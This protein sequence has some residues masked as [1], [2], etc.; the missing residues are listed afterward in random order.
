MSRP[1]ATSRPRGHDTARASKISFLAVAALFT[2]IVH[3]QNVT[4]A[5]GQVGYYNCPPE[6]GGGCCPTG[7]LCGATDCVDVSSVAATIT[8]T[9]LATVTSLNGSPSSSSE[10]RGHKGYLACQQP[11]HDGGDCCPFGYHCDSLVQCRLTL[12]LNEET[13]TIT[14]TNSDG[15]FEVKTTTF[16]VGPS[17]TAADR[18]LQAAITTSTK[19]TSDPP[20]TGPAAQTDSGSGG[21]TGGQVGGIVGGVVG[22]VLLLAAAAAGVFVLVRLRK[23]GQAGLKADG[24]S[25]GTGGHSEDHELD[26]YLSEKL[27]LDVDVQRLELGSE[28][29]HVE[30][31]G[32]RL[33]HELVGG[34][35]THGVSELHGTPVEWLTGKQE[36]LGEKGVVTE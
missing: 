35:E 19:A 12:K 34:Y 3:S 28:S 4:L 1:R 24:S 30:M 6:N 5:C 32:T 18:I 7:F 22:S 16:V 17:V 2:G 14:T 8:A 26:A 20:A 21:L 13:E 27:E 10:C 9:E 29:A 33:E 36:S 23:R 15:A 25:S 11:L 31:Q